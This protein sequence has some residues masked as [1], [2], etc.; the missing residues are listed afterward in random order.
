MQ[1]YLHSDDTAKQRTEKAFAAVEQGDLATLQQLQRRKFDVAT[2]ANSEGQTLLMRASD[3]AIAKWL[4]EQGADVNVID[5]SGVTPLMYAAR[6]N[7]IDVAKLLI[8]AKADLDVES[9]STRR[10]AL[11]EAE[12]YRSSE[13]AAM[14]REAGAK[15]DV[16]TARNGEPLPAGGGPQLQACKE[17]LSA[18]QAQDVSRLE[19]LVSSDN[20]STWDGDW[21]LWKR[22]HIAEVTAYEGFERGDHATLSLFGTTGGGAN[23]LWS[24]QLRREDGAWKIV[25][26]NWITR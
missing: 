12:E 2:A 22:V 6:H 25:R 3:P 10:T 5:K 8:D 19:Q 14:L 18:L 13:I 9:P 24:Y 21:D 16:I 15:D 23:A 26:E 7:R 1:L 4:V 17:Y 20:G 11:M